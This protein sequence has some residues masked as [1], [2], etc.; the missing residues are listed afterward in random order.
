MCLSE[1]VPLL[2]WDAIAILLPL[3][4]HL[5]PCPGT[6]SDIITGLDIPS[7]SSSEPDPLNPSGNSQFPGRP[8]SPRNE[9]IAV[10]QT[11]SIN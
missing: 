4:H 9:F 1:F 8:I 7:P 10:D 3:K 2:I 11:R 6:S 5:L